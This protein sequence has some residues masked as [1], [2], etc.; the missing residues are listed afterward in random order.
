M[1]IHCKRCECESVIKHGQVRGKQRYFCKEC[2]LNFVEGDGRVNESLAA[3]K[4]VAVLFYS[5]GK[6]SF[7]MLGKIFGHSPS[8]I[9]RW[10]VAAAAKLPEPEVP[11]NI[12]EMEFDEMWHFIGSKKTNSG[13]S[14]RW[15]VA[16]GE[17]S[18]G[19]Q[20]VVMLQRSGGFTIKSS[21]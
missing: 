19:L 9:Y 16:Q 3:K 20:A 11:V 12:K 10:I 15:I 6:A 14:K 4:A 5:L 1:A 21:T 18:P 13:S 17:L 8:L 7:T 2:D